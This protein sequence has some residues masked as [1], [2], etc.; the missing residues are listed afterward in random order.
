MGSV[1]TIYQLDQHSHT[2]FKTDEDPELENVLGGD[3]SIT[4]SSVQLKSPA[5]S[6][7]TLQC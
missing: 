1:L 6:P 3:L 2:S 4:W 5:K 7:I